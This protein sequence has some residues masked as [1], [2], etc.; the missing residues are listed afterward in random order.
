MG[1]DYKYDIIITNKTRTVEELGSPNHLLGDSLQEAE[2]ILE[3]FSP[4][5]NTLAGVYASSTNLDKGEFFG[6]AIIALGKARHDF[7]P[8]KSDNFPAFAKFLIVD[9]MNECVKRNKALIHIPA[10]I[11]KS[12]SI[13]IRIKNR[14]ANY[15][16]DSSRI[17]LEDKYCDTVLPPEI[18][19]KVINDITLLNR[20]A[21][22]AGLKY[23]ELI[24]KA[25]F[26]P[27]RIDDSVLNDA[28]DE[29]HS[30][31]AKMIVDEIRLLMDEDEL[32]VANLI[33][34]D[35]TQEEIRTI[36][37]HSRVWVNNRMKSIRQKVKKM[38][39]GGK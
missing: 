27:L 35:R 21:N 38:V 26:L 30:I 20:A 6:E 17:L 11:D 14:I 24:E 37:E 31:M 5:I 33:M 7:N 16:C 23:K 8:N 15:N 25:E 1:K 29:Q 22:R 3:E 12:H 18:S 39:M 32:A 19:D 10:Y 13:I 4:Y 28:E 9:A 2:S 36:L 34:E